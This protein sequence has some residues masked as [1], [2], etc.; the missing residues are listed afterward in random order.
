ML[1]D[2]SWDSWENLWEIGNT[3]FYELYT[4]TDTH[5]DTYTHTHTHVHMYTHMYMYMYM[6]MYTQVYMLT[7]NSM[8]L[9]QGLLSC[10]LIVWSSVIP[11]TFTS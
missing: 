6:Y 5:T 11:S 1:T 4:Q 8:L 10:I 7:V 9:L 3:V 2:I